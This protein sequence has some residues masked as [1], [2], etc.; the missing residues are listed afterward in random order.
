MNVRGVA[1]TASLELRNVLVIPRLPDLKESI[2][3]DEDVKL[4]KNLEGLSFPNLENKEIGILI[5]ANVQSA[6]VQRDF[7]QGEV[8][9]PN[10]ILTDLGWS[11]VGQVGNPAI[12]SITGFSRINFLQSDNH[13]LHRQMMQMYHHD[14]NEDSCDPDTMFSVDDRKAL[15]IMQKSVRLSDK[16]YTIALPW[17]SDDIKLAKNRALAERRLEHLKNRFLKDECIFS[18]YKEKI[19]EY[20]ENGFARKV[21]AH[22]LCD[23]DRTW[24]IPHHATSGKF[25]VVFDCAARYRGVSLNDN[26]LQGPDH[27]SSLVGVLLRFR[28]NPYAVVADIR[29]MFHQVRVDPQDCDSLRFLWWPNNDLSAPPQDFQMMVHLFGA[30]SSPSCC[31]FALQKVAEDQEKDADPQVLDSILR[32]FYVDD[33]LRSFESP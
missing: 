23:S 5:G 24:Y 16:H 8:N 12:E 7:R 32:S 21:P 30:T 26:L 31:G 9:Q 28:K 14:F 19:N 33:F 2:P 10:A 18:K 29:S 22:L 15:E 17:K 4:Y 3:T 20:L 6:H 11:L 27:T 13:A 1:Q 25:R